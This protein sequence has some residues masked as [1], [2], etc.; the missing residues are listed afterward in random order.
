MRVVD[1]RFSLIINN[2]NYA[3]YIG[4]AIESALSQRDVDVEVIVVDDGSIDNSR[5]VIDRYPEVRAIYQD[6]QGQ[7][8]AFRTG[9]SE[10]T[11]DILIQIDSDDLLMPDACS[12]IA[13]LWSSDTTYA[14]FQLIAFSDQRGEIGRIPSASFTQDHVAHLIR[15][16][17]FPYSPTTGNAYSTA[18]VKQIMDVVN[19]PDR[20]SPDGLLMTCAPLAGRSVAI[21]KSLGRYRIHDQNFSWGVSLEFSYNTAKVIRDGAFKYAGVIGR[22]M[23]A[24]ALVGQR[25]TFATALKLFSLGSQLVNIEEC[26]R[27]ARFA[28]QAGLLDS[29][30]P[31]RDRVKLM[32]S[33]SLFM[34]MPRLAARIFRR[35]VKWSNSPNDN[36]RQ[37]T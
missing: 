5:E 23:P 3:D 8:R 21:S 4:Q 29:S 13:S 17:R 7:C 31:I 25:S 6:N 2:Y 37:V 33:G 32:L 22:P 18:V 11:G 19:P 10:A 34:A 20:F 26:R 12:V 24:N 36:I 28:W 35:Q 30:A 14:Q 9:L 27:N 15:K 16:G 1:L